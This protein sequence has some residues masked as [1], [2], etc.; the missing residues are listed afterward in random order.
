MTINVSFFKRQDIWSEGESARVWIHRKSGAS[1]LAFG[2]AGEERCPQRTRVFWAPCSAPSAPLPRCATQVHWVSTEALWQRAGLLYQVLPCPG[3][4]FLRDV[5][6][7]CFPSLVLSLGSLRLKERVRHQ[8]KFFM[9]VQQTD[10]KVKNFGLF[11]FYVEYSKLMT[12][13][14]IYLYI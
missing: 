14:S 9:S 11:A 1:L 13:K 10:I 3:L 5:S 4:I 12:D 7:P 6:C 8:S 2:V